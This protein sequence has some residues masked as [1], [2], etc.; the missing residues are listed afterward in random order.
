MVRVIGAPRLIPAAGSPPKTIAEF[1]GRAVSGTDQVSIAMMKSPPGWAEPGQTPEFDEYSL[2]LK[3]TLIVSTRTGS[4]DV[5]SGQAVIVPAGE[6]VQYSSPKGAEY[7][8]VCVPAFSPEVVHRDDLVSSQKSIPIDPADITYKE[9]GKDGLL[10]IEELWDLLRSHHACNARYFK[11]QLL[12]RPFLERCDDILQTNAARELLVHLAQVRG[13]GPYIGFCVSSAASGSYGEIESIFVLPE[14]RSLG[15]GTT[16]MN[17]ALTWIKERDVSEYR[18]RVCEGNEQS[19][20][21]YE[22]FGFYLRRHL[23]IRKTEVLS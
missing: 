15:I 16:F 3:G 8:A 23:L 14:Y 13:A 20:R 17:H 22:R 2:V 10:Y 12:A 5:Q 18:V 11:D 4:V 9:F 1:I 19:F 6:W 7:L 21:F